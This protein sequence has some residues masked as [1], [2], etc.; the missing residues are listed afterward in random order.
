M[1]ASALRA[2]Q[3]LA[4]QLVQQARSLRP[5]GQPPDQGTDTEANNQNADKRKGVDGH[6]PPISAECPSK[7][8]FKSAFD[9]L[10]FVVPPSRLRAE[11]A[12]DQRRRRQLGIT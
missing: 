10:R 6:D 1:R 7:P 5:A 4:F 11:W 8:I 3:P 2:D 9:R 12:R